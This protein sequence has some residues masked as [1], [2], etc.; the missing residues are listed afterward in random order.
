MT[1]ASLSFHSLGQAS[2]FSIQDQHSG[3]R[4]E[5]PQATVLAQACGGRTSGSAWFAPLHRCA[6]LGRQLLRGQSHRPLL[7][8][9]RGSLP[10]EPASA[11]L[12]TP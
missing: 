8:A 4:T 6:V 7:G 11:T 3:L 5:V 12:G 10:A 9:D 2:D 1:S